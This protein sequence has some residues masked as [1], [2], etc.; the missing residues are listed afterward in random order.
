L[1]AQDP[2]I[3]EVNLGQRLRN[4]YQHLSAIKKAG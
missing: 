1:Q 3:M 2:P 4:G